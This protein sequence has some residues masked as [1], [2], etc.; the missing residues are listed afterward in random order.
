M[1]PLPSA[2]KLPTSAC[3]YPATLPK[4]LI[5]YAY[6]PLSSALLALGGLFIVM[7]SGWVIEPAGFAE[8][9][10]FTGNCVVPVAARAPVSPLIGFPV[11]G[12]VFVVTANPMGRETP[13]GVPMRGEDVPGVCTDAAV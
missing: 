12:W 9:E 5:S 13:R 7:L 4:L 2:V 11:G 1:F 10:T 3:W 6:W 8:S